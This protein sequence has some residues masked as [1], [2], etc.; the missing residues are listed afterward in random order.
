VV[1]DRR[2]GRFS[3]I[4]YGLKVGSAIR[5]RP[6]GN[7]PPSVG[8]SGTAN[9][10]PIWT[11]SSDLGD[12]NIYQVPSG[13]YMGNVGIGVG[14]S[15]IQPLQVLGTILSTGTNGGLEFQDRAGGT[16]HYGTWYSTGGVDRF[17]RSDIGDVLGITSAGYMGVGTVAPSVNFQVS[18]SSTGAGGGIQ[19]R[20]SNTSTSTASLAYVGA[21]ANSASVISV[22][23]ADGLGTGPLGT[24][25]AFLGSFTDQPLGFVTDDVERARIDTSGNLG[26]GTTAPAA[27]LEVNGTAKFDNTVTFT[28]GQTFPNT[29]SSIT[30]PSSG[31]LTGGGSSSS[32]TLG[33]TT[34][35]LNGQ[36]LQWNTSSSSWA[37]TTVSG[38][39]TI[40]GV[41]AGTDLTG[42]G[43]AGMVTLN[44]DTTKVPQLASANTF[45]ASQTVQGNVI[46]QGPSPWID[47]TAPPYSADPTGTNDS[48]SAIVLPQSEMESPPVKIATR[49]RT[50]ERRTQASRP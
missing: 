36:I 26:I 38:T 34:S 18:G 42:G 3:V 2:A 11:S 47:V 4:A 33:L 5:G 19:I 1:Y 50:H 37:C 43:T 48:A 22:L 41:T 12:S 23:A 10:I 25:S 13:T 31:G 46:V 30:T 40:T 35:C 20:A 14:T 9:Y 28:S 44:V 16:S 39:G 8:G 29:I 24:A 45:T 49:E 21:D 32:L 6:V 15:P 27:R 17:N 7:P